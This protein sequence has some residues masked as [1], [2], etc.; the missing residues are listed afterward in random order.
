MGW[1]WGVGWEWRYSCGVWGHREGG[2]WIG[3]LELEEGA[4]VALGNRL[5]RGGLG[6]V[7]WNGI[8]EWGMEVV[9]E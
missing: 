2:G 1:G 8:W 4:W 7:V 9:I 3:T 6:S 5:G